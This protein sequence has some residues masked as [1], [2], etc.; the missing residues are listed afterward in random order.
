[1]PVPGNPGVHVSVSVHEMTP[2]QRQASAATQDTQR[3]VLADC[4]D[5]L[6]QFAE[7]GALSAGE[8]DEVS[9]RQRG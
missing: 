5:D 4:L 2:V 6:D 8:L 9:C 7:R 1:V 3:D